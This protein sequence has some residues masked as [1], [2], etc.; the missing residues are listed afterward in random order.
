MYL[1]LVLLI[2]QLCIAKITYLLTWNVKL[3]KMC[4]L[5]YKLSHKNDIKIIFF[6]LKPKWEASNR[7]RPV[8]PSFSKEHFLATTVNESALT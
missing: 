8:L 1:T 7:E 6:F 3:T 2:K 5:S 4:Y